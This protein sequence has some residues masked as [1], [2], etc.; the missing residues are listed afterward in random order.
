MNYF[1]QFQDP[2]VLG[3]RYQEEQA[4]LRNMAKEAFLREAREEARKRKKNKQ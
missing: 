1:H 2:E 4:I 3:D